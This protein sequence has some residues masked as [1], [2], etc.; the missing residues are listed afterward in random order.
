MKYRKFNAIISSLNLEKVESALRDLM[1][2]GISITQ[3]QGYG[4][5]HD[6]Y[7][8]DMMCSHARIEIFC[9]KFEAEAIAQCIMDAAH[10]GQPGDGILPFFQSRQCFA[11]ALK[12][13][14]PLMRVQQAL[15]FIRMI[16]SAMTL[17]WQGELT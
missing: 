15:K 12:A 8:P 14:L 3:V 9:H 4:E 11:S 7:K 10:I 16:S 1:V 5:Y 6:F 13:K 17:G 2:S